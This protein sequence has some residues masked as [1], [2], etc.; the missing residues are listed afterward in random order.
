VGFGPELRRVGDNSLG[1]IDSVR[2][3]YTGSGL[4]GLQVTLVNT[5]LTIIRSVKRGSS[6]PAASWDFY[7]RISRSVLFNADGST[8]DTIR[9]VLLGR[10]GAALEPGTYEN[11]FSFEYSTVN[12]EEPDTQSASFVILEAIGSLARG[13]NAGISAGGP[14]VLTVVNITQRGDVNDDDRIDILD[15]IRIVSH[16]LERQPLSADERLRGDVAP[17]PGGD[18]LVDVRDLTLLQTIIL[19]DRYPD[20]APVGKPAPD[21]GSGTVASRNRLLRGAPPEAHVVCTVRANEIGMRLESRVPVLGVQ[22]GLTG[23]LDSRRLESTPGGFSTCEAAVTDDRLRM[24][25]YD[26][27]GGSLPSGDHDVGSIAFLTADLDDVKAWEV[28]VVGIDGSR[29][30]AV[31]ITVVQDLN[32]AIPAEYRLSQNFPNPFNPSTRINFALPEPG[33]VTVTV[34]NTVG[35]QVRTLVSGETRAGVH[36]I[37][38]DGRDGDGHTVAGGVYFYRM[39]AG[40]LGGG[41]AQFVQSKKMILLK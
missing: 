15:L 35:Q 1:L 39:V 21:E 8:A 13:Q 29:V 6:I 11:L 34:Y 2:L 17:W 41:K 22:V 3:N 12:I 7:S 19:T 28:I 4:K 27:A 32:G 31:E 10:A 36:E 25:S 37:E 5:G 38:W 9:V 33:E 16:I 26:P 20:G 14:S 23:V 30:E 18:G 40:A 24:L